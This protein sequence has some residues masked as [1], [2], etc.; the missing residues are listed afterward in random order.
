MEGAKDGAGHTVLGVA[1]G[2]EIQKYYERYYADG[3]HYTMEKW[4]FTS[5][6]AYIVEL[7]QKSI[8]PGAKVLD[9]GCG[10]MYL[11]TLMPEFEWTGIDINTEKAKGKATKHNLE[12]TPYP[13]EKESFDAI[14]CSEVLEHIFDPTIVSREIRRLIK[15]TGTYIVSTPNH[16]Y[17]D[18]HLAGFEQI[19]FN[20]RDSWRKEHIHQYTVDSHKD[21]FAQSGFEL[22]S[23]VGADAHF[24]PFMCQGR[25]VL[26]SVVEQAY[27]LTDEH[28]TLTDQ[29]LG[30]MFPQWN[31][32]IILTGRPI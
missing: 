15:P 17:L 28:F 7:L 4:G 10:D 31:H 11:S 26:R 2:S 9:V 27:K 16:N 30:A 19:I 22:V 29:I 32:T 6:V 8:K 13:L 14:V 21:I 24:S 5:R 1:V 3:G 25:E 12:D 18:H 23:Y 20:T